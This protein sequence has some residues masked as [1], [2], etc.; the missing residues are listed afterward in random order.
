MPIC[1]IHYINLA[2]SGNHSLELF[3]IA[4]EY[5]KIM[6]KIMKNLQL[7]FLKSCR[8]SW[9]SFFIVVEITVICWMWQN[10]NH[11]YQ[12]FIYWLSICVINWTSTIKE[13]YHFTIL[14]LKKKPN[15]VSFL[16]I[17]FYCVL[18][19]KLNNNHV[20]NIKEK[21]THCARIQTVSVFNSGTWLQSIID[22]LVKNI[23]SHHSHFS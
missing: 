15:I 10:Y 22:F 3:I 7:K 20:N 6:F 17:F 23:Y 13:N 8:V 1:H 4:I 12:T 18:K 2:S 21:H 19:I 5:I 16:Y 11:A 14:I 9:L